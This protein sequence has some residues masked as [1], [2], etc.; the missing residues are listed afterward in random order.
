MPLAISES[1]ND[2]T[3]ILVIIIE[4]LLFHWILTNQGCN[5]CTILKAWC[6]QEIEEHQAI[7]TQLNFNEE[8]SSGNMNQYFVAKI[9]REEA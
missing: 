9:K 1:V 4:I 3:R 8:F 2:V 5:P 7:I 6:T